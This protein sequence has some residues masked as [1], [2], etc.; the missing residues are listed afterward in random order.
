[1]HA[2]REALRLLW[3]ARYA[4]RGRRWQL[5]AAMVLLPGRLAGRWQRWRIGAG[6]V[7]SHQGTMS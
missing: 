6:S 5:T 1:M 3:D 2:R 7:Y 4:A